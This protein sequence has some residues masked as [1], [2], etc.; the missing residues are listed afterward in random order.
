MPIDQPNA[1]QA[2]AAVLARIGAAW[3]QRR[4][5]DLADCFASDM[6]I[7]APDGSRVTGRNACV[8]SYRAFLDHTTITDY[9]EAPPQ[10]DLLGDAAVAIV[11]WQITWQ[12]D[13]T[14]HRETGRDLFVL[15]CKGGSWRAAWRMVLPT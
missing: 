3:T 8:A 6:I 7:V 15:T 9:R 2:V 11:P 14:E 12:D 13:G 5:A 1:E 4:Y 10:I